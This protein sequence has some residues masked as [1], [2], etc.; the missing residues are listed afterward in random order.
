MMAL[1]FMPI[2]LR[3]AALPVPLRIPLPLP[4]LS[5]NYILQPKPFSS[6]TTPFRG[7]GPVK[8]CLRQLG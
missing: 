7:I 8:S 6:D 5:P 3:A 2:A 4:T 1:V